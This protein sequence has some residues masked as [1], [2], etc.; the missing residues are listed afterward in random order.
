MRSVWVLFRINGTGL[1]WG[2]SVPN[3]LIVIPTL[4]IIPFLGFFSYS[5]INSHLLKGSRCCHSN[6]SELV[7]KLLFK[8]DFDHLNTKK[9]SPFPMEMSQGWSL[10]NQTN[11]FIQM[12]E[13]YNIMWICCQEHPFSYMRMALHSWPM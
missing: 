5:F 11:M 8:F 12:G 6:K 9:A 13:K 3:P 4:K 7:Q 1:G 2:R 10:K